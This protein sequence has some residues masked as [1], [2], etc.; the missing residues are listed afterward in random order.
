MRRSNLLTSLNGIKEESK[1]LLQRVVPFNSDVANVLAWHGDFN[2]SLLQFNGPFFGMARATE[3]ELHKIVSCIDGAIAACAGNEIPDDKLAAV[4]LC[5]EPLYRAC[6]DEGDP[7]DRPHFNDPLSSYQQFASFLVKTYEMGER[8]TAHTL[9]C[10]FFLKELLRKS[11]VGLPIFSEKAYAEIGKDP[12]RIGR[13]QLR[14]LQRIYQQDPLEFLSS[15]LSLLANIESRLAGMVSLPIFRSM[16]KRD[17]FRLGA[18]PGKR[19]SVEHDY[20]ERER[21]K[22]EYK[23]IRSMV[24]AKDWGTHLKQVADYLFRVPQLKEPTAFDLYD[25]L[26]YNGRKGF[27][28]KRIGMVSRGDILGM[29]EQVSQVYGLLSAFASGEPIPNIALLGIEGVG[30]TM[31]LKYAAT[32]ISG[33]KAAMIRSDDLNDIED[34]VE[35]ASAQPYRTVIC[36]GDLQFDD[37]RWD[38][39]EG[40]FREATSGMD[41]WPDNLALGIAANPEIFD[42][43][44]DS[45]KA[46]FGVQIHYKFD[47]N[48]RRLVRRVLQK[49]CRRYE[50]SYSRE[51]LQTLYETSEEAGKYVTPRTIKDFVR[52]ECV[53]AKL[54]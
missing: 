32:H 2:F 10:D 30:K 49:Y 52:S 12:L 53:V 9:Y 41:D 40:D 18:K 4:Y 54:Q 23:L 15:Y 28:K 24:R 1:D 36:V 17:V 19:P 37:P 51:L 42:K 6:P 7:L 14:K 47:Q 5:A 35:K 38:R 25:F 13:A 20:V 46:R 50:F 33:L 27:G 21:R 16:R 3:K 34:I 31:T 8:R 29:S 48:D 43:L 22:L 39:W 44:H 45:T 11:L 26:Q